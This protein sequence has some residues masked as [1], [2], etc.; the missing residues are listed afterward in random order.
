MSNCSAS[1]A[2]AHSLCTVCIPPLTSPLTQIFSMLETAAEQ[3]MV[4][5]DFQAAFDTCNKGLENLTSMELED[6]R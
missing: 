6:N 2:P 5:T 1:A 3:M 4:Q